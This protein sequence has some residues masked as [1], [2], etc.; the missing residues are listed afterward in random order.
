M[1]GTAENK[2]FLLDAYALI[3]RAYYAFIRNPRIT[4]GG[5]NTSAVFG[6]VLALDEV[7]QNQNP[8]HIAV[9]FDPP[10]PTFRHEMYKEYKANRDAT[11]EDIKLAVPYIKE[12][13]KAYQIPVIEKAGFEADDVIGTLSVKAREKGFTTFMMTPDKDFAQLVNEQVKMYKPSRG[14]KPAEVWGVEEVCREFQVEKPEQ[15]IDILALAGDTADNIPGAPG[16]GPKTAM[17]LIQTY[18]SVENLLQH[19]DD[20]KGKQKENLENNTEQVRLSKKLVKISLD[21]PVELDEN[22]LIR[23]EILTEPLLKLFKELEFNTL[24]R[25]Y[26]PEQTASSSGSMQGDLFGGELQNTSDNRSDLKT[27]ESVPHA[28][29]LVEDTGELKKLCD[30]LREEKAVCFDTETTGLDELNDSLAG[31]AFSCREGEAWYVPVP[32]ERRAEVLNL[33]KAFFEQKGVLKIGQNLKYDLH[34][35]KNEGIPVEGPFFDTLI[36]HYLLQSESRH[37][38]DFLAERY[39]SYKPISIESLIG[40]KGKNQGSMDQLSASAIK[41]YACEDA[42]ITFQL[43]QLFLKELQKKSLM[44]L[45]EE[46]EMPLISVL[47][48]MEHEGVLLDE[49]ALRKNGDE[50]RQ[51]MAQLEESILKHAGRTFNLNSPKQLG[52][53]LFNDLKLDD[54][55]RKTKTKQYST[56]E[57]VLLRLKDRHPIVEEILEYRSVKKLLSTYIE[58]LPKLI[59]EKT[60]R[61]HTRFMQTVAATGRLSSQNPNLQNIPIREERGRKIREAFIP[62][63]GNV[64]FSADYSQIELRLMAHLSGDKHMIEAFARDEDIHA[65]TAARIFGVDQEHVSR[66][67]RSRAKVANF[68][69]IYGISAFG[70]SQRLAISRT[71]AKELIEGYFASYPE[72]KAYMDACIRD[73]REKGYVR[74]LLGRYRYLPDIHSRNAMIRG[75]AERNAINAPIQGSASDIIK[76]AMISIQDQLR[77]KQMKSKMIIQVHD[78][79]IFTV[80]QDEKEQL[81]DL[82]V[83]EMES[84]FRLKVPLKT[85]YGFGMNWNEAH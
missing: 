36:A 14:G 39:L 7:L 46:V 58:A 31:I 76:M 68:G 79:L 57:E 83:Q 32:K 71:E 81:K 27:L 38:M 44:P 19:L 21:V 70:L 43:Y 67:M 5:M 1:S 30:Q 13:L 69:I 3:F 33:L 18:G 6:F 75:M 25:K 22:Q 54:K 48:E 50:L 29:T 45:A 4:S 63:G 12:I 77:Q 17:K 56:N 40:P 59:H 64:F 9:V 49:D 85:D 16:I 28:Y 80:D 84:A 42:D 35:L 2:L 23:S 37:N 41:D 74:T 52:E 73:A 26:A 66:E 72:V 82:V 10:T 78:E 65:A 24:A 51:Q 8:S 60:G 11:P 55:A 62:P 20:L 15:V 53:I 61:I 34:I 47:M